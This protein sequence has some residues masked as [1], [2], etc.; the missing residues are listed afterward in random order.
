MQKDSLGR[1]IPLLTLH[2]PWNCCSSIFST[3]LSWTGLAHFWSNHWKFSALLL[4][5]PIHLRLPATFPQGSWLSSSKSRFA[6]VYFATF[7]TLSASYLEHPYDSVR[8]S[9]FDSNSWFPLFTFPWAI[10]LHKHFIFVQVFAPPN[11]KYLQKAC[12][13]WFHFAV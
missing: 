3:G 8:Q 1:K 4:A 12:Y 7:A 11:G 9:W 5:F 10:C 13:L 6:S 2:L